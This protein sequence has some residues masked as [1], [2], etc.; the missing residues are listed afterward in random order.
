M[1]RIRY[2]IASSHPEA[3]VIHNARLLRVDPQ[4]PAPGGPPTEARC[5]LCAPTA[6]GLRWLAA[7]GLSASAV[8][9]VPLA[10][11]D[12]VVAGGRVLVRMDGGTR[13]AE[14]TVVHVA[15]R[16]GEVLRYVQAYVVPAA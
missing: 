16:V 7:A 11:A 14:W 3:P 2:Q 13:S 12:G 10:D 5:T 15:T 4:P 1:I 6:A 8:L 9:F